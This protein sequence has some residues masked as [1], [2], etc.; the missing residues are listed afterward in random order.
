MVLSIFYQTKIY[1]KIIG[2]VNIQQTLFYTVV[3]HFNEGVLYKIASRTR[4]LLELQPNS[5]AGVYLIVFANIKDNVA[6]FK[7]DKTASRQVN[8]SLTRRLDDSPTHRVD[9]SDVI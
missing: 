1:I 5:D 3:T 8:D 2:N 4:Y 9:N 7:W 6:G